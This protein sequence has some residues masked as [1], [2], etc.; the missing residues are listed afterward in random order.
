MGRVSFD[1]L[2]PPSPRCTTTTR[3]LWWWTTRGRVQ[4][5]ILAYSEGSKP[6]NDECCEFGVR[7]VVHTTSVCSASSAPCSNMFPRACRSCKHCRSYAGDEHPSIYRLLSNTSV[8]C[9]LSMQEEVYCFLCQPVSVHPCWTTL[10]KTYIQETWDR[11]GFIRSSFIS[12]VDQ[13]SRPCL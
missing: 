3:V 11:E 1:F 4:S 10:N 12:A 13:W 8:S 5:G 7:L 6:M 2:Q 9:R